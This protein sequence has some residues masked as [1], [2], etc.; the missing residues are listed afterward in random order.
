MW[1]LDAFRQHVLDTCPGV[2]PFV[3]IRR[4]V[5]SVLSDVYVVVERS[6]NRRQPQG[7][8]RSPPACGL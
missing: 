2:T 1:S 5:L 3:F 8:D 4:E 6:Y 7:N